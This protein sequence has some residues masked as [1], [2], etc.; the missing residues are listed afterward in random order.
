MPR[1]HFHV[2]LEGTLLRDP[3]G[4]QLPDA[5]AAWEQARTAAVDLM[6][7]D[8]GQPVNG[9]RCHFEVTDETG[10]IV[11]E[12]PFTEAMAINTLPQRRRVN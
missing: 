2:S 5:D 8:F 6:Q 1:Y 11:L 3:H 7:T 12:F 10:G 4:R 9:A